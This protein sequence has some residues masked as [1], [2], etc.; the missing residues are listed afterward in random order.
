MFKRDLGTNNKGALDVRA[1]AAAFKARVTLQ[2]HAAAYPIAPLLCCV[3]T[4]VL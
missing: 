3:L 4:F 2:Q 1:N